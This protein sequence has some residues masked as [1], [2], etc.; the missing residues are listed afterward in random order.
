MNSSLDAKDQIILEQTIAARDKLLQPLVGDIVIWPNDHVRRISDATWSTIYQTCATGSFHISRNGH[1][2]FSGTLFPP[3]LR[4][5]LVGTSEKRSATFWFFHHNFAGAGRAVHV[6]IPVKV[7]R[8]QPFTM[9]E[10]QAIAHPRA[11]QAAN[12]WQ[13]PSNADYRKIVEW[14]KEPP[15]ILDPARN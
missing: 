12:F 14:L 5:Y 6:E 1:A 7:Y 3:V 4:E 8:L 11:I 9:S 10:E 13:D 15:V 2:D